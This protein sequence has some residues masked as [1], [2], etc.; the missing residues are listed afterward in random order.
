MICKYHFIEPHCPPLELGGRQF[1]ILKG[2]EAENEI[3]SG[4]LAIRKNHCPR[5]AKLLLG[6]RDRAFY[7]MMEIAVFIPTFNKGSLLCSK[8]ITFALP[9]SSLRIEAGIAPFNR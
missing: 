8:V 9:I 7:L 1:H 4:H 3:K 5:F 6:G 2:V